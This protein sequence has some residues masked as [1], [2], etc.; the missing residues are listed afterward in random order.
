MTQLY[1]AKN[2]V[3]KLSLASN[4]TSGSGSMILS[5]GQGSFFTVF[6]AK[7]TLVTQGT[8]GTGSGE[9]TGIY[10]CTGVSVNTLTGVSAIEG[11]TDVNW[12]SGDI[13][14]VRLTAGDI[15]SLNSLV[16]I[17]NTAQTAN[18]VLAGPATGAP[19][20]PT[21]RALVSADIPGGGGGGS[22]TVTT[23][24]VVSANGF[25]GSVANA[26]TT[27]AITISTTVTGIIKGNGTSIS[28]GVPGTDYV[29][30]AVTTLGSLVITESQVTS[31]VGDLTTLTTNVSANSGAISTLQGYFSGGILGA[32]RLPNP[33]ASTLGGV[34]SITV[35]AHQFLTGISTSGVPSQAQPAFT[36]ISGTVG[37]SQLPNPSASTL[38]GV[39]SA[40]AVSHQW[41]NSISTSGVP[42]L[43]QPAF[44]D[45]SGTAGVAQ[46]GTGAGSFTAYA[47]L[48]GGT[49]STGNVQSVA[50]V[51]TSGQVLTSNGPG[52]LPTFQNATAGTGLGLTS[53]F[54][55]RNL[56]M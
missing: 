20:V 19:A 28:A 9:V 15:N 25:A 29:V 23:V 13:V 33:S 30:P 43:S 45:I 4:Y 53:A 16:A 47:V 48:C 39:Q 14:E 26:T 54:A 31:L 18:T 36:D 34:E 2:N 41:I 1:T 55:S 38:G 3:T 52:A 56:I 8:Y 7:F 51:G 42:S 44:T 32:A 21:F 27:P 12:S 24:S 5:A 22:G 50:G 6:P 17:L 35:V 37:A 49:T 11:T 40:A 10:Q 46:G